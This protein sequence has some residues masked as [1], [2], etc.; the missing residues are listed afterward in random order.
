MHELNLN[1]SH[2]YAYNRSGDMCIWCRERI[3][4]GPVTDGY[5]ADGKKCN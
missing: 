3:L 2:N 4:L 5:F 1:V